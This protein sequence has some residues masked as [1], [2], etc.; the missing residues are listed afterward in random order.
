MFRTFQKRC[1]EFATGRIE[2]FD[3]VIENLLCQY[4]VPLR[5]KAE[6]VV[7]AL[8]ET[9]MVK[10]RLVDIHPEAGHA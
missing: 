9:L 3:L 4:T 5:R 6:A 2:Q 10:P 8:G 1:S 7:A